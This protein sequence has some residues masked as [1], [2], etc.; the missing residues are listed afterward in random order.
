MKP[1]RK[2]AIRST[3]VVMMAAPFSAVAAVAS[4]RVPVALNAWY[5]C[6]KWMP[7][8]L[9]LSRPAGSRSSSAALPR[10]RRSGSTSEGSANIAC[11]V[12]ISQL[13]P[14]TRLVA[15][16]AATSEATGVT[17][18]HARWRS[19]SRARSR[20]TLTSTAALL[21]PWPV[22]TNT[23]RQPCRYSAVT[24][25]SMTRLRVSAV[26]VSVPGKPMW[27]SET[28]TGMAGAT[29]TA[30]D[31]RSATMSATTSARVVSVR[32]AMP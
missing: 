8:W 2:A 22:S 14:R 32:W 19:G 30:G 1:S 17:P 27:C 26:R 6:G 10:V 25:S 28:P 18:L 20:A 21:P 5:A 31:R 3:T 4:P 13:W 12:S 11:D 29:T 15:I 24:S 16:F 23:R 9:R 7:G